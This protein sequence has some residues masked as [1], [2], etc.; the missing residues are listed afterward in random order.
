MDAHSLRCLDCR[1]SIS[2]AQSHYHCPTCK[3]AL[4]PTCTCPNHNLAATRKPPTLIGP[5]DS[6]QSRR[7]EFRPPPQRPQTTT[8]P[9]APPRPTPVRSH[10]GRWVA[11]TAV[12]GIAWLLF[13]NPFTSNSD[14][15]ASEKP[16]TTMTSSNQRGLPTDVATDNQQTLPPTGEAL[17]GDVSVWVLT[18]R[19][20][21]VYLR[22]SPLWAD[23]H[24]ILPDGQYLIVLDSKVWGDERWWYYVQVG[25]SDRTGYVPVDLTT[26]DP[27]V[28]TMNVQGGPTIAPRSP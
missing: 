5:P 24:E 8:V 22:E 18:A 17:D 1:K 4:H 13:A 16:P 10:R 12:V 23:K 11:L 28:F 2:Q 27:T 20:Q 15:P 25:D 6:A 21:G 14:P 7:T 26:S 19:G 9:T 3:S